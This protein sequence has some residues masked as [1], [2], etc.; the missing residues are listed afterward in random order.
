MYLKK[1]RSFL[2]FVCFLS[3]VCFLSKVISFSWFVSVSWLCFLFLV[4]FPFLTWCSTVVWRKGFIAALA[5]FSFDF[6]TGTLLIITHL[7]L[8]IANLVN[9]F[10][11]LF[12][13]AQ[14]Q[15]E[16]KNKYKNWKWYPDAK[17]ALSKF[18][19]NKSWS[20]SFPKQRTK[21]YH[22]CE[23]FPCNSCNRVKSF[24]RSF[25][26]AGNPAP[27]QNRGRLCIPVL[28]K[29]RLMSDTQN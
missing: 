26:T 22:K 3:L 12:P 14:W 5:V 24:S 29:Q 25:T 18:A 23:T 4:C 17:L 8:P 1:K 2:F 10:I 21:R 19:G 28:R 27:Y 16:S 7:S 20:F 6:S 11:N 9:S 15:W 13:F